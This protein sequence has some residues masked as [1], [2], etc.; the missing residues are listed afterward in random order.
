MQGLVEEYQRRAREYRRL[1]ERTNDPLIVACLI[2]LAEVYEEEALGLAQSVDSGSTTDVSLSR[3][4][5]R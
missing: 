4:G 3:Q 2:E 1:L 5:A